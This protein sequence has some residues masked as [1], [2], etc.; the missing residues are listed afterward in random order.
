MNRPLST[1]VAAAFAMTLASA[2]AAGEMGAETLAQAAN[3]CAPAK[4]ADKA[5][6]GNPCAAKNPCAPKNPCAAK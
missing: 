4:T 5:K 6:A 1:L 2:A 3:P